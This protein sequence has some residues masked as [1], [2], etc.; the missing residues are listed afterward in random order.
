[1]TQPPEYE[2]GSPPG[3]PQ[4]P[5]LPSEAP[6]E[7]APQWPGPEAMQPTTQFSQPV[8]PE[9][10]PQHYH[11]PQYGPPQYGPPPAYPQAPGYEQ[12]QYAQ[13]P[14]WGQPPTYGQPPA[15]GEPGYG[16][17][18]GGYPPYGGYGPPPPERGNGKVVAIVVAVLAVLALG[19]GA[20]LAFGGNDKNDSG[21]ATSRSSQTA[22]SPSGPT[23]SEPSTDTSSPTNSDTTTGTGEATQ[24]QRD[25]AKVIEDFFHRAG[26]RDGTAF[27]DDADAADV[28]EVMKEKSIPTCSRI[29]FTSATLRKQMRT[30]SIEARDVIV[31]GDVGVALIYKPVNF[32]DGPIRVRKNAAG[33]WKVRLLNT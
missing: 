8:P 14:G 28:K 23:S 9:P 25:A 3:P 21:Q 7:Q 24:D 20:F 17:P 19:L 10:G 29:E 30:M 31:A 16:P 32:W 11:P 13:P 12:P 27:C 22:S 4:P 2:P 1:V 18:P 6:T 15:Y 33:A 5:Q 26:A